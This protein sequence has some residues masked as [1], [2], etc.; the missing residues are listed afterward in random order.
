VGIRSVFAFDEHVS[1]WN[2]GPPRV[3]ISNMRDFFLNSPWPG[4]V[5]WA[6]IY[7]SDFVLTIACARLRRNVA[8]KIVLEG[9]FELN[10]VF[11]RDVDS[12]KFVSP[13]FLLLLVLTSTLVVII[14]ALTVPDSTKA[15]SFLLG[16]LMCMEL[17]LHVR[18]LGNL[19]LFSS[20][21]TAEQL[22]GRVEYARPL[23]LRMSSVQILGFTILFAVVFLF[24]GNWFV[25]GG[26]VSCFSLSIKHW[27]LARR[28]AGTQIAKLGQPSP[29]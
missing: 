10:P 12:K 22:R 29:A 17:A 24:T 20:R 19:Y 28:A 6:L 25:A 16:A 4:T 13:R 21:L 15:Y 11:Q 27:L 18:H 26:A 5:A 8:D 1:N 3:M 2:C 7:I 23:L 9:S 14:W